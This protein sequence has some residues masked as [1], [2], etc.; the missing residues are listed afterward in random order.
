MDKYLFEQ[1]ITKIDPKDSNDLFKYLLLNYQEKIDTDNKRYLHYYPQTEKGIE[2]I[3]ETKKEKNGKLNIE[4][5]YFHH[6]S[7]QIWEFKI[8]TSMS[9][10]KNT[11]IVKRPNDTGSSCIRIVNE[12]IISKKLKANTIIK[13]QVCGIVML[14]DIYLTEEEYK[15]S[16]KAN[17][18]GNKTLM[19]DGYM[20]PYNLLVNNNAKL[21][22]E[23]RNKKYHNRDNLLT[24]KSKLKNIKERKITMFNIDMPSYYSATIDTTYGELDIIIPNSIISKNTRKI[25]NNNIIVGELLL[26][27]DLCVDKYNSLLTSTCEGEK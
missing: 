7:N 23:E 20:I 27:F 14:A 25:E 13:G 6:K 11:Y 8:V 3:I 19:N 10:F 18:D 12:D 17:K 22:E 2:L 24:F 1:F 4:E 5:F 21:S 9:N 15:N 26:S 16:I